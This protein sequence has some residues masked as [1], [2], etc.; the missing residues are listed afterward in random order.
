M[1]MRYHDV[2]SS[3]PTRRPTTA[4][5]WLDA[6]E[7]AAWRALRR[8]RLR[9]Q[10]RARGRPRP[11]RPDARRLPGARVPVRGRR[12]LDADVRP[13]R[14]AAAVAERAHPPPRRARPGRARRAPAVGARSPG[15]ARRARPT[16]GLALPRGGRADPR[17]QRAP[18]RHRPP[19]PAP[20]SPRMA[21]IF[22]AIRDGLRRRAGRSPDDRR[23][24]AG[25]GCHV[26]NVGVKDDTDDFVVDRRRP[27]RCRPP[28]CSPAAAF[29]GPS[30]T[31]S[32]EHLADGR[33]QAIVVV[34]KNANVA[35]GAGRPRRRRRARR[36]PSPTG[37]GAR[38]P[39]C[40][41]RR[42]A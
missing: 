25:F 26:A 22:G 1:S 11:A 5:P 36:R 17:A 8:D 38:R 10:R 28:A 14:A 7:M 40:S 35:N 9:P 31:I 34:S 2:V 3:R 27:A 19:R 18:P 6:E 4:V 37:S 41:S 29:A 24:P 23:S 32:R 16:H 12:P 42:P 39:T 15:D 30:V 13:G 33:A 20:T 21:R